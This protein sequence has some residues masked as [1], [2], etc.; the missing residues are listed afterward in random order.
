MQ[1]TALIDEYKKRKKEKAE[2]LRAELL[3]KIRS[4]LSELLKAVHFEEAYI[5]GSIL[6]LSF[7]WES[8]IDIAFIGLRDKDLFRAMAFLS[9][10]LGR[11]VD[12]IQLEG[13]RLREKIRREGISVVNP[14]RDVSLNGAKSHKMSI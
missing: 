1:Q 14:D 4:A 11:D 13:H 3:S 6:T 12:V 10:Y 8:D 2:N 7:S 5:F 9:D